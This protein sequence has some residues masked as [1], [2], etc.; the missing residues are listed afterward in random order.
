MELV[1]RIMSTGIPVTCLTATL[2]R[3]LESVLA[4]VLH[5]PEGY[6]TI[7]AP[8]DREEHQ[9]TVFKLEGRLVQTT[10]TFVDDITPSLEGSSRGIIFVK[11]KAEGWSLQK[12][13]PG[14]DFMHGDVLDA[15]VRAKMVQGWKV[16]GSKRWIIGTT[17]LIQGIDYPDVDVVLFMDT[18]WGMIDFVQGAG[19]GGRNG[20]LSKIVLIWKGSVPAKNDDADMGCAEEMASWL[21]NTTVCRRLGISACMDTGSSTC[22]SLKDAV[23]CDICKPDPGLQKIFDHALSNPKGDS[24]LPQGDPGPLPQP[25]STTAHGSLAKATGRLPIHPLRPQAARLTTVKT[26]KHEAHCLEKTRQT[27][28]D[29]IEK[30]KELNTY[31]AICHVLKPKNGRP[32]NRKHSMCFNRHGEELKGFYDCNRPVIRGQNVRG[33][34][35]ILVCYRLI[36]RKQMGWS[37]E[38]GEFWCWGCSLPQSLLKEK[39]KGHDFKQCPWSE[40]MTGVAWGVWHNKELFKEMKDVLD[41]PLEHVGSSS[42]STTER[43]KGWFRWLAKKN[44]DRTA[45]NLHLLWLWYFEKKIQPDM[46]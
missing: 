35:P 31:C 41:C 21:K 40:T 4:E 20:K 30:L 45:Y 23:Y 46:P 16:G 25:I 24:S 44:S 42:W 14:V 5:L 15:S 2:P 13:L 12:L 34:R 18:T 17:S 37:Y 19:R 3:R 22:E 26:A 6:T 10:A 43:R 28:I 29:C 32:F 7:R 1:Y 27:A 39:T 38:T 33:H 11:T 8:T 9:Y 36:T